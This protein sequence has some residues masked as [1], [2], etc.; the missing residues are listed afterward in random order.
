MTVLAIAPTPV[1][2]LQTQSFTPPPC[3]L[4]IDQD[5]EQILTPDGDLALV[6][7]KARVA[8]DIWMLAVTPLGSN[9]GDPRYGSPL[10]GLVGRRMPQQTTLNGYATLLQKQAAALQQKR[11]AQGDVPGAGEA[12]DSVTATA[13]RTGPNSL[14]AAL[15][16]VTQDRQTVETAVP[17]G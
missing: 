11:T 1:L 10:A 8:Q 7:G 12:I 13:E 5:G 2:V 17:L 3:D 16:V 15:S 4:G 14:I 6:S 9:Y